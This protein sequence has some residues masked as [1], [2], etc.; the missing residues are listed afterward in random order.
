MLA[1]RLVYPA[2]PTSYVGSTRLQMDVGTCKCTVL[3][4][5]QSYSISGSF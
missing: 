5:V 4:D 3:S 2:C 1:L